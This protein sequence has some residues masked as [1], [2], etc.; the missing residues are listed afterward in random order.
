MKLGQ[1]IS[2]MNCSP[3]KLGQFISDMNCSP[4]KLGQFISDMPDTLNRFHMNCL[5][6]IMSIKWEDKVPET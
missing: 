6:K 2:D 5:R 1:F 3:V 4:V